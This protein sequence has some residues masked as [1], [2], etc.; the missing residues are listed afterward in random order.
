MIQMCVEAHTRRKADEK[1]LNVLQCQV[2]TVTTSED[3]L[4]L[5]GE[6][7]ELVTTSSFCILGLSGVERLKNCLEFSNLMTEELTTLLDVLSAQC[8]HEIQVKQAKHQELDTKCD[9]LESIKS[10]WKSRHDGL[11]QS[12]VETAQKLAVDEKKLTAARKILQEFEDAKEELEEAEKKLAALNENMIGME[13]LC[14]E[15]YNEKEMIAHQLRNVNGV[16]GEEGGQSNSSSSSSGSSSSSIGSKR[17]RS[18]SS[19]LRPSKR[20]PE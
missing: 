17:G 6:I 4:S 8:H 9:Q 11:K 18:S 14:S 12:V 2:F 16:E 20:R 3:A 13:V 15:Y 7:S 10:T 19:S 5:V 1:Q